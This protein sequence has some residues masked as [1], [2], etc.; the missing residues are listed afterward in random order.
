MLPA[1]ARRAGR[2]LGGHQA[3]EALAEA[4]LPLR[5]AA[6]RPPGGTRLLRL[7]R[8]GDV[9]KL[10]FVKG[11][12]TYPDVPLLCRCGWSA[13]REEASPVLLWVGLVE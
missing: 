4:L 7:A 8:A 1:V 9:G 10:W 3:L 6:M 2:P 11:V 12:S 5:R 13:T